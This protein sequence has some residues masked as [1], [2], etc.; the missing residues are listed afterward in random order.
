MHKANQKWF[1]SA[2]IVFVIA[3]AEE[4]GLTLRILK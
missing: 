1:S 2:S 3:M 4:F